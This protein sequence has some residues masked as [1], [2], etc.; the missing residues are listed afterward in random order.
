LNLEMLNNLSVYGG[1]NVSHA[2]PSHAPDPLF[3]RD[4]IFTHLTH[5][6]GSP[7]L[8]LAMPLGMAAFPVRNIR[9]LRKEERLLQPFVA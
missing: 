3:F 8:L 7:E 5:F 9:T 1:G 2:Q 6:L 4:N